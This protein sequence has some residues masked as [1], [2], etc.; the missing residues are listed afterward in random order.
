M[1]GFRIANE[2]WFARQRQSGAAL[3]R[4][5]AHP[6]AKSFC[7]G[8]LAT[9]APRAHRAA[10][11]LTQI[12]QLFATLSKEEEKEEEASW[13]TPPTTRGCL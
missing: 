11:H 7:K 13:T 10:D 8:S 2:F 12:E 1:D 3:H 4:T 5:L 9:L 6:A